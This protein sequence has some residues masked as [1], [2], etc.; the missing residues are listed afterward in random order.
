MSRSSLPHLGA[1]FAVGLA[2]LAFAGHA[3]AA[4]HVAVPPLVAEPP[5]SPERA[6]RLGGEL[7]RQLES[8]GGFELSRVDDVDQLGATA[9]EVRT[10]ALSTGADAVVAGRLAGGQIWLE[11]RSSHSG[12]LLGG[13]TVSPELDEGEL[14]PV[15]SEMRVLLGAPPL[16]GGPPRVRR[17]EAEPAG[18]PLVAGLR[19]DGPI[20]IKSDSLDVVSSGGRRHLVFSDNVRVEQGDILLR[21]TKLD[22]FY[23]EGESQPERLVAVGGVHVTQGGRVAI[24]EQATYLR[25]EQRVICRG[26]AELVQGCDVVRGSRI[27]FDLERDHFAVK[28]A[29]S[30]VLGVEQEGGGCSPGGAS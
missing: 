6:E 1:A 16:A 10:W 7:E 23:R 9:S 17:A 28:G 24:C 19:S 13:W 22:A 3:V 30:V 2:L 11:L 26:R 20:S 29:A 25:A 4:P 14:R 18:E 15:L 5:E 27:E 8:A 12:G 21:T